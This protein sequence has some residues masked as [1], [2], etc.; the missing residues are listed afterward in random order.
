[1][2]ISKKYRQQHLW[3]IISFSEI[4]KKNFDTKKKIKEL[5]VNG[6][7]YLLSVKLLQKKTKILKLPF[8]KIIQK[9]YKESIDLDFENQWKKAEQL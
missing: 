6:S 5:K 9:S 7:L 4:S 2:L 3:I 8:N 1:M